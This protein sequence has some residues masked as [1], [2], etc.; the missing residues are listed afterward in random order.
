ME[1]IDSWL[2]KS[3]SLNDRKISTLCFLCFSLE[4]REVNHKLKANS[5]K[6]TAF[7]KNY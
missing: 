2:C 5:Y 7:L 6:L 3:F 1:T 4:K